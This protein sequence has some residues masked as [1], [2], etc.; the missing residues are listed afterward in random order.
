MPRG[1][2]LIFSQFL[3]PDLDLESKITCPQKISLET[4]DV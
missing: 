2:G 3:F 4:N 1:Q